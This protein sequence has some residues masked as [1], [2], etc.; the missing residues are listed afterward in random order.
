MEKIVQT[1]SCKKCLSDFSITDKDLEF[2]KKISPKFNGEVCEIPSPTF[3]PECREQRRLSFRNKNN[4]YRR[5]CDFSWEN[6]ISIYSSDKNIKVYSSETYWSD[7]WDSLD[8]WKEIDFEKSFFEQFWELQKEVPHQAINNKLVENCDYVNECVWCKDCYLLFDS[9]SSE[10]SLYSYIL[11]DWEN[12]VDT[13]YCDKCFNC[14]EILECGW[15][16]RNLF[17]SFKTSKSTNS[18]FLHSCFKCED[19]IWCVNLSN[20]KYYIFNEKFTEENY[21][22][23][24]EELFKKWL[25]F[26]KEEYEKLVKKSPKNY[27]IWYANEDVF[28]DN[29]F[30]SKNC[31]EC[32]DSNHLENC[33]YIYTWM[34]IKDS[35]DIYMFW[36]NLTLSYDSIVI[37]ENSSKILF[38]NSCINSNNIFYSKDLIWC[39][40][41]FLSIWLRN[42]KYCILNKQY[43]KEEYEKK[44]SDIIKIMIK[45]WEWWEFFSENISPF[46]K[47]NYKSPEL[48]VEKIISANKLPE[49]ISDI[50]N[51]ILNWAIKCEVSWKPFRI[52][53]QELDFYRKHNLPIPKKHP[54]IRHL[55]R[56]KLR[57]PRKLFDR[58]CDKCSCE[59]KSTYIEDREEIIYCENCY[60]K[61]V[62]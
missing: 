52:I 20:K 60:D 11:R 7:K 25:N 51:D 15:N 55:E 32:Y 1:K 2:Y 19:C 36:K 26:I 42:K 17:Y 38:S 12:C 13:W 6:I 35:Y 33:K 5:K 46:S 49:K 29:I 56:M 10:N 23:K 57:N 16:S 48:K 30:F 22:I 18:Y 14:Y 53:K 21:K 37:W 39:S 34:E 58:K 43:T 31:F 3:C 62:Y 50:P 61:E 59:I 54:D 44:V 28:W 40:N 8:Y 27:M 47:N 41:C 45:N 9:V 24:K 4:L